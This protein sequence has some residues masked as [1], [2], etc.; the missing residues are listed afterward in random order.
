MIQPY[1]FD[2]A[3]L[4]AALAQCGTSVPNLTKRVIVAAALVNP[5]AA[6]VAVS[7]HLVPSSKTAGSDNVVINARTLGPGE[8]YF[9]PELVNQGINAAGSVFAVGLGAT[10]RYTA[11]DI[12]NG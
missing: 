6:P 2:G 5:T 1:I 7:V 10:F 4:T 3:V 9:C 11:K 12:I 8:T